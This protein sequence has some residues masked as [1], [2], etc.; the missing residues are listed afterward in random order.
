M[1]KTDNILVIVESPAKS[2]TISEI[3]KKAGYRNT[4]VI[5][6]VGHIVKLKDGGPAYNSGIYPDK[7]FQ[8]SLVVDPEKKKVV[9]SISLSAKK[10]SKI[11]IMTDQDRAGFFIGWSVIKFCKLPEEKCVRAVTHEIT[12]KAVVCAIENPVP[13]DNNMVNAECAR[14]MTDKLIG[15]SLSPLAKKYLG[16]KSV[17]RCQ[18]VGLKLISDREKEVLDFIPELYYNLYL[19]FIKNNKEFKA[20]YCG[21]NEESVEKFT[22]QAD[23]DAIISNCKNTPFTVEAVDTI[24][25]KESPK[26]PFCTAT[27]QQE[28]ATKLGLKV[29]D[30]M[31][32]AQK[33]FEGLKVNGEH[34]GLITYLR[35]DSTEIAPEFIPHLQNYII[36]TY[37]KESYKGPRKGKSKSTDQNGHEA[38]R[39]TDPA[40]TPEKLAGYISNE[41]L[42]KVYKLIWQR[43]IAAAM[44]NAAIAETIYTINNN[45]HKFKLSSKM[46][47]DAGYRLV[48]EYE[49]NQILGCE[50]TFTAGEVLENTELE[51]NKLFTKPKSRYSE[52]ALVK[53]LEKIG[54]GRPSTF[55]T[56]VETVL[57]PTRGYAKLEE[58]CIVP[59]DRGMQ[60]A[61][62][63]DRSF[64][65]LINLNYTKQME[66]Q[67]DRIASGEL[68]LLDYMDI[69]YKH[70]TN[71]ITNTGEIGLAADLT[72]EKSCPECGSQM[73]I[74][75]SR[76]GKLFYGCSA[77]PKCKGIINID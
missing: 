52:A 35:S 45:G 55:A 42:V 77:Y 72:E 16:A 68:D 13:F 32:C 49:D 34:I 12:P 53:E 64:S 14:M 71:V 51:V 41:L 9:E 6:S 66:E 26:P 19:K 18:S 39:I 59:T 5:A 46:L 8:M 62:Y 57:S 47:I 3:L 31:S 30:A 1:N 76:F 56:I 22:N 2:K 36:D 75:R 73:V 60:L 48:Y 70:L 54:C 29:K 50:E 15:Y 33:L 27:F 38:L 69:F 65:T 61:D 44:P 58:K 20:K 10:A 4:E 11:V 63:C 7:N 25:H 23:V 17:G 67:L 21:Y 28:A 43:T 40:M 24:M 74:R 37:G